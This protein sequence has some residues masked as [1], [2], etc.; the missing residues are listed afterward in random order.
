MKIVVVK[1]GISFG[2]ALTLL[3]TALK[4]MGAINCSWWT[5][6]IAF[7]IGPAIALG[8]MGLGI[9]TVLVIV[10]LDK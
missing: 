10:F 1:N 3:L 9:L 2:G 7:W 6:F 4:L 8:F 5:V